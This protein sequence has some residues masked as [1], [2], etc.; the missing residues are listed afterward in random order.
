MFYK[1][2]TNIGNEKNVNPFAY[3][4]CILKFKYVRV[5]NRVLAKLFLILNLSRNWVATQFL[6]VTID[7][8]VAVNLS[9]SLCFKEL[10]SMFPKNHVKS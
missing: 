10:K 4:G 8:L 7:N 9:S 5:E 6:F 3:R 1:I 2:K